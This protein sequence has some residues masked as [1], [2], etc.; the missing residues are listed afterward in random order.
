MLGDLLSLG[1]LEEGLIEAKREAFN[2]EEFMGD[3]ISE[4]TNIAKPQQKI[5]L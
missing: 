3:F 5:V 2:C 4:M 1:K